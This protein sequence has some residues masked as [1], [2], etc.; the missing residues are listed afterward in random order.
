MTPRAH[1]IGT[2]DDAWDRK[3]GAIWARILRVHAVD[4]E[5][6]L[7]EAGP[8]FTL[9]IGLGLKEYG[10]RGL[11]YVIEPD[12]RAR[13]WIVPRYRDL[14]PRAR[15]I[16]VAS[17]LG[18]SASA[19]PPRLDAL[20]MNHLLDDL[21]LEA[22]TPEKRRGAIFGNMHRGA[23]CR[24]DV[25]STWHRLAMRPAEFAAASRS[26]IDAL[27]LVCR[28]N[29]PK[30]LGISQY[31]SWFQARHGLSAVDR[32]V[33]PLLHQLVRQLPQ[34]RA[35]RRARLLCYGQKERRWLVFADKG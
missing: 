35:G 30:L 24:R 10:F 29:R 12:A 19:L 34:A 22:A 21:V 7:A 18:S 26:V 23:R 2:H 15:V 11:L 8:G 1:K 17:R 6:E 14:L 33:A 3:V 16:P 32:M 13:E 5:G 28:Q 20:L 4:P 25:R 9:K 27:C 31:P